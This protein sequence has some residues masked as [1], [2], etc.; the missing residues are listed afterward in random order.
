MFNISPGFTT[1]REEE[2]GAKSVSVCCV[3]ID[4]HLIPLWAALCDTQHLWTG[5]SDT[6]YLNINLRVLKLWSEESRTAIIGPAQGGEWTVKRKLFTTALPRLSGVQAKC[7]PI[8]GYR[9]LCVSGKRIQWYIFTIHTLLSSSHQADYLRWNKDPI[10]SLMKC[11]MDSGGV[12]SLRLDPTP[13][14]RHRLRSKWPTSN[15]T[16]WGNFSPGAC[17]Q[18]WRQ[19]RPLCFVQNKLTPE[20]NRSRDWH[21]TCAMLLT[22]DMGVM[23]PDSITHNEWI[24]RVF[25]RGY[26]K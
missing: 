26:H 15:N 11:W 4:F 9:C 23:S 6:K 20:M 21:Q 14:L 12:S 24:R 22:S 19:L 18:S 10:V 17:A 13:G 3:R 2:E 8:T 7:D 25:I 1:S 16:I 5:S